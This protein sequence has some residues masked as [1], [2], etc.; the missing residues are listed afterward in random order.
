MLWPYGLYMSSHRSVT[1][2]CRFLVTVP[3]LT[4]TP[5]SGPC[6]NTLCKGKNQRISP[7]EAS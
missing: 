5:L 1:K 2:N 3:S 4:K 6:K 7:G